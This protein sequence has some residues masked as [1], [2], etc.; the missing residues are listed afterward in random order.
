MTLSRSFPVLAVFLIFC[1]YMA[2]APFLTMSVHVD[3][4]A[5]NQVVNSLMVKPAADFGDQYFA[6]HADT[7]HPLE[8]KQV[9]DCLMSKGMHSLWVEKDRGTY[10]QVC[11]VADSKW[12][13]RVCKT[14]ECRAVDEIT[15]FIKSKM[16]RWEQVLK[17]LEN[18]GAELVR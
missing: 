2:A 3:D 10:L 11:Q 6:S 7:K 16:S 18:N 1:F 17:Y 13:I 5:V 8:A 15:A 4:Q 9:R 14:A 12:G